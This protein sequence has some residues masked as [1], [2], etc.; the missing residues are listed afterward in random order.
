M[1]KIVLPKKLI[2][3]PARAK[4][5]SK[6]AC[7]SG[8]IIATYWGEKEKQTGKAN[9]NKGKPVFQSNKQQVE[10]RQYSSWS[11]PLLENPCNISDDDLGYTVLCL[12]DLQSLDNMLKCKSLA[13]HT[14]KCV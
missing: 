8:K 13:A 14:K 6:K 1:V 10:H 9:S 12:V 3:K 5:S 2:A 7:S 4:S 11:N